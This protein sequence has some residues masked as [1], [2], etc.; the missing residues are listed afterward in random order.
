MVLIKTQIKREIREGYM[1]V[2]VSLCVC[3][4]DDD[5]FKK[6]MVKIQ[7]PHHSS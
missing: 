3:D 4:D 7:P 6:Q 2:C 1:G 5:D